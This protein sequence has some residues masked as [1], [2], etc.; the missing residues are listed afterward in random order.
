MTFALVGGNV[1]LDLVNTVQHRNT[2]PS[3]MLAGPGDLSR[4]L[5]AA[6]VVDGPAKAGRDDFDAAL[7]LR[8]AVY[9]LA[10]GGATA[11]DRR[12]VNRT[13]KDVPVR[14]R[15]AKDGSITRTGDAAAAI[16]TV[17]R[18][19][20]ELLAGDFASAV[21]ECAADDCTLL[22]VDNSRR[23][24]RR[25]CDMRGCG[26]RAKVASFRARHA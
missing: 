18:A 20:V 5:V 1:A 25:W 6:R 19:A 24:S 22:Y 8:E 21:K 9:R 17:A 12:L 4:W 10:T 14:V 11:A 15:L 13:A 16:A 7:R 2:D 23:G 3:D 26:N